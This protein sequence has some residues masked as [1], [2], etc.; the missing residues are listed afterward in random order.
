MLVR[1]TLDWVVLTP[2]CC[3]GIFP[4]WR[5]WRQ[6][7]SLRGLLYWI[8]G[9]W[10]V[11]PLVKWKTCKAGSTLKISFVYF[12][13]T[14]TAMAPD[15][16]RALFL[17]FKPLLLEPLDPLLHSSHLQFFF[18][19]LFTF[20]FTHAFVQMKLSTLFHSY[21]NLLASKRIHGLNSH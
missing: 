14:R 16:G 15:H 17:M 5:M 6:E 1:E 10:T 8:F 9:H 11:A 4:S 12:F 21:F 19:N 18:N 2:N 7:P 13:E 3:I 20:T